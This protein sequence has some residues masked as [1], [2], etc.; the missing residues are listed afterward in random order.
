M[1]LDAAER[2]RGDGSSGLPLG[3]ADRLG[4]QTSRTKL[5]PGAGLLI[6]TDGLTEA[7]RRSDRTATGFELFGEERIA[8]LLTRA[9]GSDSADV[10][11]LMRDEVKEFS[12]GA[13]ADDL[14]MVALRVASVGEATEVCSPDRVEIAAVG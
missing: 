14:C 7:R 11:E 10:L 4:C 1:Q 13:L 3:V 2:L 12:G 5:A 9:N 6:Y 8:S